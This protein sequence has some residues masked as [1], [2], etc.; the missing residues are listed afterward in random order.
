MCHPYYKRDVPPATCDPPVGASVRPQSWAFAFI[1]AGDQY[2]HVPVSK[3]TE[4]DGGG[5]LLP[6]QPEPRRELVLGNKISGGTTLD[7]IH[8]IVTYTV[9]ELS[10]KCTHKNFIY[11]KTVL[12][13]I[14]RLGK[15]SKKV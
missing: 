6:L 9:K 7:P 4:G 15:P 8:F 13:T 10:L 14:F 2:S 11:R 3:L 5:L 12:Q 1:C